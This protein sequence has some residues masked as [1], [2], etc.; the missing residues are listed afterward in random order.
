MIFQAGLL[1]GAKH[2]A[3]FST[4]HLTDTNKTKHDDNQP[5]HNKQLS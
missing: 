1:T 2:P 3:A 5:Q 4:N